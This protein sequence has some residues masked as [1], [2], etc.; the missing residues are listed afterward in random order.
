MA[1]SREIEKLQR[2]WQE[3]PLGLT[4]APLAEAYRKEGLFSDALELLEIGLSQ[5]PTYVPAHIVKGRCYL[6]ARSDADAERAFLKVALLDPENV[7]ALQSLAEIAERSG[8]FDEAIDRLDRLLEF[9]RT[10][11]EAQQQLDRLKVRR[12]PIPERPAPSP[13]AFESDTAEREVVPAAPAPP[14]PAT[15][16]PPIATAP[17]PPPAAELPRAEIVDEVESELEVTLFSPIELTARDEIEL[18][19]PSHAESLAVPSD[20][21]REIVLESA[22]TEGT[23]AALD[24]GAESPPTAEESA[25]LGVEAPGTES[26]G[27]E[28]TAPPTEDEAI[29]DEPPL[30]VTETMAEIFLRQGHRD[31]ALA[32]YQQLVKRDLENPRIRAAIERLEAERGPASSAGL[33]VYAAV[34]TGGQSVRAFF[35]QLLATRRPGAVPTGGELSLGSVF[36][37]EP[38]AVAPPP[39]E[40]DPSFDE[41]FAD[42]SEEAPPLPSVERPAPAETG[43]DDL[44]GFTDWLKGL[45]R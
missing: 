34:L 45:R 5:H 4:F 6:D 7:I 33:P 2:R 8:R 36:G 19:E 37:E 10:N 14:E 21:D 38:A 25:Q 15:A 18:E 42:G 22:P 13:A 35:E 26:L 11:E 20:R 29:E 23:T 44:E 28:V 30:V 32:V 31:L 40:P 41:F 12:S 3:N 24:E 27:G 39:S 1:P 17:A 43:A 16:E 9:D